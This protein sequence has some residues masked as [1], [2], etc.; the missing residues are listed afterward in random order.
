M[1]GFHWNLGILPVLRN[2]ALSKVHA[3]CLKES[4]LSKIEGYA[5]RLNIFVRPKY[6][7]KRTEMKVLK[8][9]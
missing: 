3:Q 1:T 8:A 9:L 6:A 4:K 2:I 5:G 7:G